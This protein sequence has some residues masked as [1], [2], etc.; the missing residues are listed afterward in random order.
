[1]NNKTRKIKYNLSNRYIF[2][3]LSIGLIFVLTFINNY[4]FY[5]HVE[6]TSLRDGVQLEKMLIDYIN[7]D[8][9]KDPIKLEQELLS[10]TKTWLSNSYY[11]EELIVIDLNNNSIPLKKQNRWDYAAS[12]KIYININSLINKKRDSFLLVSQK[13]FK[14]II[15]TVIKSM[16]FSINEILLDIN[17]NIYSE[18]DGK[19]ISINDAKDKIY[20]DIININGKQFED[21][22]GAKYIEILNEK[23]NIIK[24]YYIPPYNEINIKEGMLVTKNQ[25]IAEG[26]IYTALENFQN[27]YWLRSRP[28]VGFTIFTVVIL[29][30]FRRRKEQLEEEKKEIEEQNRIELEK[31]EKQIEDERTEKEEIIKKQNKLEE[32]HRT[33]CERFKQ[34][35]A[36]VKFAF[37]ETTIDELLEKN[38]RILGNMFRLVAEKIVFSIYESK[39]RPIIKKRDTLDSCLQEVKLLEILKPSSINAL[40]AVKNFG[41]DNSHYSS[42]ENQTSY[43]RTIVIAKDLI[44]VIEEYLSIKQ[45]L[46]KKQTDNEMEESEK[47]KNVS[48]PGLRIVKK[49]SN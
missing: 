43:V 6:R 16:T 27:I 26:S 2:I 31:L 46:E 40:Y 5:S 34:H 19:I 42:E 49:V 47:I 15:S 12:T 48:K 1:M 28:F 33:V 24:K 8:S 11:I 3:L 21:I 22:E 23:E 25:I 37:E 17:K 14:E 18:F 45:K 9:S 35:E 7:N 4:Y 30:L 36:F 10:L 39:I 44:D 41:N 13:N 38:R 29:F 32:E 20:D